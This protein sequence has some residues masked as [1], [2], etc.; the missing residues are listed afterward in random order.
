MSTAVATTPRSPA[1]A[2][3]EAKGALR[4]HK[5]LILR[6]LSQLAVLALFLI[7]PLAGIWIV[8]GSLASSI[9]FDV[10]PLSD[11]YVVLQA[12]VAGNEMAA[13]ALM[14]A[15]I[16]GVLYALVGGRVY[17]A[18]VC[19]V[20]VVTDAAAW[21]RRQLG[22][23]NEL[24]L[25][26]TARWGL[27][28][29]TLVLALATG[30]IAWEWVNPV[31]MLHRGLIFGFGLAWTVVL[32]VFLLDLLLF[33][34]AWCGHL[35]PTGAFYSL[36]GPGALVGVSAR[37][38]SRCDDCLDCYRACPEPQVISPALR[39]SASPLV[40]SAACTHCGRCIDVCSKD[41]FRFVVRFDQ[42][43]D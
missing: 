33:S 22:L 41:V 5:W 26:R 1:A 10:L 21:L 17:C 12:L 43:R 38:A 13:N 40:R 7:G 2:A 4:A 9:T 18:W 11:P 42:R 37:H 29:A 32:G 39:G 31:S 8:K 16:V 23:R 24:R 20:N 3:I 19:P 28:A 27:L 15:A 6:R 34:R 36:L 30:A 14:G 25:P 35:C